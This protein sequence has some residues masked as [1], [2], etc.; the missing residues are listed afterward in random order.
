ME[1]WPQGLQ[2][3][4]CYPMN[5]SIDGSGEGRGGGR[6]G[7]RQGWRVRW[8]VARWWSMP[9]VNTR[10]G[11]VVA[12]I[13]D[14]PSDEGDD[15]WQGW[16]WWWWRWRSTTMRAPEWEILVTRWWCWLQ[17][18]LHWWQCWWQWWWWQHVDGSI[19]APKA[20]DRVVEGLVQR[21]G[22]VSSLKEENDVVFCTN[23]MAERRS[24]GWAKEALENDFKS[25]FH[26]NWTIFFPV[27]FSNHWFTVKINH[28]PPWSLFFNP[29]SK[30]KIENPFP[31]CTFK[32]APVLTLIQIASHY[33][34]LNPPLLNA[35]SIQILITCATL[36]GL[37]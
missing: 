32:R 9:R 31:T 29:T 24:N 16:F 27:K 11:I 14:G 2:W 10:V 5:P 13:L 1:P 17:Q 8:R 33:P 18:C 7:H 21:W 37:L 15:K 35:I 19:K 25:F 34:N 4:W 26:W 20:C 30:K 36:R 23:L 6:H 3:F 28:S 12:L 22:G